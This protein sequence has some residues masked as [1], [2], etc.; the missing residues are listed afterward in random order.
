MLRQGR[1]HY[2]EPDSGRPVKGET[3]IETANTLDQQL[4]NLDYDM[5][6]QKNVAWRYPDIAVR[7][8]SRIEEIKKNEKK[9]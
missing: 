8:A 6:Q 1:W 4:Y 2:I 3:G 9:Q 7:M 5:G